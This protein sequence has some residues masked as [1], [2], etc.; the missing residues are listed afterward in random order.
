MLPRTLQIFTLSNILLPTLL[1]A[2]ISRHAP[3]SHQQLLLTQC[4]SLVLLGMFLAT[5][6]T[7]NFSLAF[8]IGLLASPLT[9]FGPSLSDP[10]TPTT[11]DSSVVSVEATNKASVGRTKKYI[12]SILLQPLSPPIVAWVLCTWSGVDMG[13][14]LAES[15]FGWKVSGLWTQVVVWCVWWPAWT[16]GAVLANPIL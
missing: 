9:F 8:L 13:E 4:V 14:L 6:A 1:A 15:A 3:L 10:A 5:L 11:T 7:L 16:V 12:Q 2:L